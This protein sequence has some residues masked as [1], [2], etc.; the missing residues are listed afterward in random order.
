MIGEA[1]KTDVGEDRSQSCCDQSELRTDSDIRLGNVKKRRGKRKASNQHADLLR[2][3]IFA[4]SEN[5]VHRDSVRGSLS[6]TK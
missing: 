2:A 4:E 1:T 5:V 6:I 3:K